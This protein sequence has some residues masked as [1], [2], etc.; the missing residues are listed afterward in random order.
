MM[1]VVGRGRVKLNRP[2]YR[3]SRKISRHLKYLLKL[4]QERKQE[5]WAP[6]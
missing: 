2:K 4:N 5:G 6:S 1:A 3:V